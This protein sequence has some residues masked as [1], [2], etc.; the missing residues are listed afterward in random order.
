MKRIIRLFSFLVL[1]SISFVGFQGCSDTTS[2]T[3]D[4]TIITHGDNFTDTVNN[5][6]KEALSDSEVVSLQFMREEE[7]LARDVYLVLYETWE[8]TV[9]QNIAG[10]EQRHM[11][12]MKLLLDKYELDDPVVSDSVGS[13]TNP[14]F[15]TLFDTLTTQGKTSLE[16]ALKVGALIEEIDI[17]DLQVAL[18][19]TVDN[20]DIIYVYNN[21]MRGSR[22][23]LRSFVKN[24]QNLG[25]TYEP[26]VLDEETYLAIINSPMERG[27]PW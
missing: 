8:Q 19:S 4:T 6:P 2:A 18:D 5:L 1:V 24:L 22:N 14:L 15:V 10:S 21:L 3:D 9:F 17:R 27:R 7:K 13:F 20:Q 23:H 26:Q 11:D 12:A 25:V 16:A